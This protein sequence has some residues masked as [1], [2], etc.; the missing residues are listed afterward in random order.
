MVGMVLKVYLTLR[1]V[2]ILN[3]PENNQMKFGENRK[4]TC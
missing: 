3:N 1:L 2:L 4:L